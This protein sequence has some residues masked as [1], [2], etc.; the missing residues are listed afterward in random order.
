MQ[1]LKHEIEN[2]SLTIG[3]KTHN[4]FFPLQFCDVAEVTNFRRSIYSNLAI[5]N[6][7]EKK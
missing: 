1:I 2:K 3:L 4:V 5:T 7:K 6:M